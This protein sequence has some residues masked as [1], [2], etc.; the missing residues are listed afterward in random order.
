MASALSLSKPLLYLRGAIFLLLFAVATIFCAVPVIVSAVLPLMWRYKLLRLYPRTVLLLLRVCCGLS[1]RVEGVE[2]LPDKPAVVFCKHQSTWE[3]LAMVQHLPP[4]VFVAKREL[5]W[6]PFFGLG[7]IAL[8]FITIDRRAGHRTVE[9]LIRQSADRLAKGLWV[10]IF[11]EGT[12]RPVGAPP[13]Y[14]L[15]GAI[16]AVE[17]GVPLVPVAVNSGEFWPR[18]SVIKWPGEIAMSIGPAIATE[19]KSPEQVRDEAQQ[20]I[21]AEMEQI[22]VPDRFPY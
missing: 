11:P 4:A 5:L 8:Q 2:N 22:S 1:H 10:V 16:M 13:R 18:H 7:M 20:W 14:K 17:N 21:E 6:L 12:R 15:G 19:G 9:Q 3:T